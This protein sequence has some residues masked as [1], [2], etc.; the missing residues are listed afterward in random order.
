MRPQNTSLK[1]HLEAIRTAALAAVDSERAVRAHLTFDGARLVVDDRAFELSYSARI[2]VVGAGKAGGGMARGAATV[3]GDR[4]AGGVVAVPEGPAERLTSLEFVVGG[5]PLP[6]E[7]SLEAGRKAAALLDRVGEDDVVLALISG[8]G[9]ALMEHLVPGMT[10]ADL[11]RLTEALLRSGATINELNAVRREVSQLK[12][13]GLVRLAEPA[14]VIGLILSDVVGDPLEVIASGPTLPREPAPSECLHVLEKHALE[15]MVP[16]ALLARL[17]D[18]RTHTSSAA[19]SRR[20]AGPASPR[21]HNVLVGSNARAAAAAAA[22]A[23]ELGFS[24]IVL[25]TFLEG[26]AREVGRV[27]AGLAKGVRRFAQPLLAPACVVLGGE[28]TVTVRGSGR[29]GRNQELALSAAMALDGWEEIAV[30]SFGTDG[31]DGPTDAAGAIATGDTLAR[32]RALGLSAD[33]ALAAN[34]AYPFFEALGDLVVTG[35][36]GTNVGDVVVVLVY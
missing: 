7:G 28:T 5:H 2:W 14:R 27:V 21:V 29:G 1:E 16:A 19:T 6:D 25:T 8:G 9:S 34:D 20:P 22:R 10:L 3:L 23:E 31:I 24:A 26:E 4:L 30:M 32:A 36:T 15:G 11:R 13:G 18:G 17:R 33:A 12:G 35:R